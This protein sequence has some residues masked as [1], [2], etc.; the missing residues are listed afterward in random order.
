MH[1]HVYVHIHLFSKYKIIIEICCSDYPYS[2]FPYSSPLLKIIPRS[3][4]FHLCWNYP[5]KFKNPDYLGPILG[6]DLTDLG[7]AGALGNLNTPQG[8]LCSQN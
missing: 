3:L 4:V 5:G 7:A 1:V 6:E 2:P 8:N